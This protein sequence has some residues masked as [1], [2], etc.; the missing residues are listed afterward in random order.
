VPFV[1]HELAEFDMGD[2]ADLHNG[3]S[4]KPP[5]ARSSRVKKTE[6]DQETPQTLEYRP[7]PS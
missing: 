1:W 7:Q 6:G 5:S 4:P 2:R 3:G